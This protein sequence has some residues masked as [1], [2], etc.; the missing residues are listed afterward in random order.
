[1]G[2]YE[3]H[4]GQAPSPEMDWPLLVSRVEQADRAYAKAQ[5]LVFDGVRGAIGAAF[6]GD[7]NVGQVERMRRELLAIADPDGAREPE[8]EFTENV[9][10]EPG[11]EVGHG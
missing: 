3:R 10:A 6:S 2:E 9:F 11:Q 4:Y 1:M 5:L 8:L 7:K